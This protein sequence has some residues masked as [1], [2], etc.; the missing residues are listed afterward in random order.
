MAISTTL[1]AIAAAAL[2]V[3]FL[4]GYRALF[5]SYAH[6]Y[7]YFDLSGVPAPRSLPNFNIDKAKPRPYRPFRWKYFQNMCMISDI[8]QNDQPIDNCFK[9]SRKWTPIGGWSWN[10]HMGIGSLSVNAFTNYMGD[11]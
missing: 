1:A 6:K 4:L 8:S 3:L 11:P 2:G 9:L 5:R 7:N 10:L